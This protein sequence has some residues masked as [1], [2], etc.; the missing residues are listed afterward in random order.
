MGT[1]ADQRGLDVA[2][3]VSLRV[4]VGTVATR[5]EAVK[6]VKEI[7]ADARVGVFVDCQTGSGME[8]CDGTNPV[9]DRGVGE[10]IPDP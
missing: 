8:T 3:G 2:V 6:N 7:P 4:P 1:E 5:H 9:S 10:D